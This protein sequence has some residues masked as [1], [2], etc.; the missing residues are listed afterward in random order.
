[1]QVTGSC[2]SLVDPSE[3]GRLLRKPITDVSWQ[4]TQVYIRWL[5][6]L[7]RSNGEKFARY[8]LPS[9][10]EWEYAARAGSQSDYSFGDDVSD[11]CRH[12]NGAD[13]SLKTLLWSNTLCTDGHGRE[14]AQ[15]DSY[16]PNAFGLHNMHGNVWEWTADCWADN[17]TGIDTT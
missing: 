13:A 7:V 12:G 5:N 1:C 4:D 16:I 10:A 9:E 2:H 6:D 3:P 15:I 8:R 17:H 14:T 11:L